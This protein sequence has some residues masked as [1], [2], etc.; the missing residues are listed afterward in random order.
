MGKMKN[1]NIILVVKPHGKRSLG[2][3]RRRWEGNIE[4]Y[5]CERGSKGVDRFHVVLVMNW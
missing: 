4:I 2:R 3:H 1:A 5:L